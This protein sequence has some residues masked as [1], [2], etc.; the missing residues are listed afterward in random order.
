MRQTRLIPETAEETARRLEPRV[1]KLARR[2][3][4]DEPCPYSR[5]PMSHHWSP[6][7]V[8]CAA[9]FFESHCMSCARA[10]QTSQVVCFMS[11]PHRYATGVLRG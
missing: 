8:T 1:R 7:G 2:S 3:K 4:L 6:Y 11:D 5:C 9:H 10:L